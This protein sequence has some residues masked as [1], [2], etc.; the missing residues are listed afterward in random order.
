MNGGITAPSVGTGLT[1]MY[2]TGC[3]LFPSTG[4]LAVAALEYTL[5]TL[6]VS[7]NV[8]ADGV[9]MPSKTIKAT[10]VQTVAQIPAVYVSATMTAT[11]PV[12]TITYKNQAGTGSRTCTMT[13]PSNAA[14]NS[15]YLMA[16]HLQSGDTGVQDITNISISTG[17]AGTIKIVG[18][19]V[20]GTS[21]GQTIIGAIDP[22]T[23]SMPIWLVA[24]SETIAF[25]HL[26][27][28]TACAIIG[29]ISGV[30]ETS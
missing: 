16:P 10:S 15:V 23:T 27:A 3:R 4:G 29:Q 11:T 7:G 17:S 26:G 19:L 28:A 12:L 8:F 20:L 6:T 18:L 13:L 24:A 14:A 9:A 5:G 25:Y 30:A 2:I 22:L 1:G 21:S